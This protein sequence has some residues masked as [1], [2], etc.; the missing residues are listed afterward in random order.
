[1]RPVV[2]VALGLA[3]LVGPHLARAGHLIDDFSQGVPFDTT[4]TA[5]FIDSQSGLDPQ[6]ALGAQR[7]ISFHTVSPA[8]GSARAALDTVP[9]LLTLDSIQ[10]GDLDGGGLVVQY[11]E[12]SSG[13]TDIGFDLTAFA[14]QRIEVMLQFLAAGDTKGPQ[15]GITWRTNIHS[16]DLV[17]VTPG[18]FQIVDH[19]TN[20][21]VPIANAAVPFT[22]SLPVNSLFGGPAN[23]APILSECNS[24]FSPLAPGAELCSARLKSFPSRQPSGWPLQAWYVQRMSACGVGALTGNARYRREFLS[25]P[26]SPKGTL[27]ETI[28]AF[29]GRRKRQPRADRA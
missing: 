12:Y 6:H 10:G 7:L 20:V 27:F 24:A 21:D 8:S 11:G 22:A 19:F 9:G 4:Y 17:E 15:S 3:C 2:I 13:G 28:R 25:G 5:G 29:R 18:D 16:R 23:P 1:M 26:S 14:S